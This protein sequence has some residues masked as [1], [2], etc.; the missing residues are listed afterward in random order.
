M[1][2]TDITETLE[3]KR[4]RVAAL[5]AAQAETSKAA[6][7]AIDSKALDSE[8]RLYSEFA[9]LGRLGYD[10]A[11]VISRKTGDLVVVKAPGKVAYRTYQSNTALVGSP[12]AKMTLADCMTQLVQDFVVTS[13]EEFNSLQDSEPEMLRRACDAVCKLAGARA[14]DNEGK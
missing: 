1:A 5:R 14:E 13:K 4:E 9:Y 2:Q 8:E 3:Q 7:D 6:Q 11:G 10:F 12:H